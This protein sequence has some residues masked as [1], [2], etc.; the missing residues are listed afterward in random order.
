MMDVAWKIKV[1]RAHIALAKTHR[2][3][4]NW[5]QY[6]CDVFDLEEQLLAY[7]SYPRMY[8]REPLKAIHRWRRENNYPTR[9]R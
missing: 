7:V 4:S 9:L 6:A 2:N 5:L 3:D 8:D 1:I